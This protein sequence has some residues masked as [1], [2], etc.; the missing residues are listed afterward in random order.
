M[1]HA[2][3]SLEGIAVVRTELDYSL[4]VLAGAS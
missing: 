2:R 3:G 4:A 1:E